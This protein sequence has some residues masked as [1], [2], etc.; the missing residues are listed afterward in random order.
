MLIDSHTHLNFQAYDDD[1]AEV[2]DHCQQAKMA[3][4]NVGAAFDSSQK[5]VELAQ[6]NKNFYASI[7]LHPIHVLD[8]EF[9][10]ADYQKLI[11]S[12]PEKVIAIGETGLDYFHNQDTKEK[13]EEIFLQHIELAKKND[14]ALIIHGRNDKENR[15][16]VYQDIYNILK[17]QQVREAVVHCFGGS[18]EQARLILDLELYLGFTGIVTFDKTGVLAEIIKMMPLDKILIET[19]APYLT[20]VPYRGKRNEPVYVKEVAV[21]IAEI[22]NM[23]VEEVIKITGDNAKQLFKIK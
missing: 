12:N 1:R 8:E 14:L 10:I 3:L 22:K 23:N 18:L 6:Q 19:D 7:G 13:Q 20:P 4:I 2:I 9:K 17:E 5:A 16:D 11:D 21:K 15:L